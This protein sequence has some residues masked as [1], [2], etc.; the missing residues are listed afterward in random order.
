MFDSPRIDPSTPAVPRD[1]SA[2]P[3][4]ASSTALLDLGSSGHSPRPTQRRAKREPFHQ[5]SLQKITGRAGV[6]FAHSSAERIIE[7][8]H[9]LASRHAAPICTGVRIQPLDAIAT[10]GA[11]LRIG[12]CTHSLLF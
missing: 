9:H 3:R 2:I 8:A 11:D 7:M 6:F 4:A 10:R 12:E 5:R 1:R